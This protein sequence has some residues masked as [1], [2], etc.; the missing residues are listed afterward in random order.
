MIESADNFKAN[1]QE[2][3][4]YYGYKGAIGRIKIRMKFLKSW[5]FH[6][7]AYSSPL[8]SWAVRYQR[9]RGVKIGKNCHISPYVLIDLLHPELIKIEDNVTISSNSMIF[10]HVNPSAN[11]FLK[12]HGYPRTIKQVIIKK[13]AV[14]SVGCI[15]VAGV[16]VGE[17]SIVGAGSV[18]T[19]DVPDHCVVVGNPARIV[20]KIEY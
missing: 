1:E 12:K 14:I 9:I 17:N 19:Q 16:T 18:V 7:L 8:P 6:T 3:M 4:D 15:I 10:A 20:K 13:G 2:L 5:I 11:E